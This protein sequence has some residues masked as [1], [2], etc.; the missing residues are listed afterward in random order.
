[1]TSGGNI[2]AHI[3][4]CKCTAILGLLEFIVQNGEV[5]LDYKISLFFGV[6]DKKH[7]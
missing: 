5:I 1:M 3:L 4:H 7:Q 6:S 2:L